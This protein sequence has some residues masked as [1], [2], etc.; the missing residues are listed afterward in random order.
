MS[1]EIRKQRRLR[2]GVASL[3]AFAFLPS[4]S[5]AQSTDDTVLFSTVVPPNVILVMDNSGSMR[6]IVWH[7]MFDPAATPAC[8]YWNDESVYYV[9]TAYQPVP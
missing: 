8:Q 4:V 2:L 5:P 3:L 7:P 9:S 1:L 6:H